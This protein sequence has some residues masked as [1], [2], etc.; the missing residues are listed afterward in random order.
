MHTVGV[1][2]LTEIS[3]E[4]ALVGLTLMIVDDEEVLL[5]RG[6]GGGALY[7]GT[8]KSSTILVLSAIFWLLNS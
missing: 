4:T 5:C 3:Q 1:D 7:L 8:I 6:G 2:D